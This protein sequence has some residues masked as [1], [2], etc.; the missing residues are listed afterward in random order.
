MSRIVPELSLETTE[1]STC[2]TIQNNSD[3]FASERLDQS[4]LKK[5][6]Q[7]ID[8]TKP[9]IVINIMKNARAT[10][11]PNTNDTISILLFIETPHY[12]RWN[13]RNN[14]L[15]NRANK[16]AISASYMMPKQIPKPNHEYQFS[17][18]MQS[19]PLMFGY[20]ASLCK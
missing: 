13:L 17:Y 7:I 19:P 10:A 15:I 11:T 14:R 3:N 8:I 12:F 18:H 9:A 4:H 2:D 5:S 1:P 20:I 16:G 6:C